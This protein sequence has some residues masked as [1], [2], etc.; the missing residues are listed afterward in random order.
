[1]EDHYSISVTPGNPDEGRDREAAVAD[2]T[3]EKL[4]S[5]KLLQPR[6][7]AVAVE[8]SV[9]AWSTS[10]DPIAPRL[11]DDVH[12]LNELAHLDMSRQLDLGLQAVQEATTAGVRCVCVIECRSLLVLPARSCRRRFT[13]LSCSQQRGWAPHCSVI[14]MVSSSLRVWGSA[15]R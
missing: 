8:T 3:A 7:V 5:D 2:A 15:L 13:K 14:R 6:V 1:M 12:V 4:L 10:R 9:P 11:S